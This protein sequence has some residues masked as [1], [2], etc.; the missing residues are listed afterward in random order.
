MTKI[1]FDLSH[2][3]DEML[4]NGLQLAG[5]DKHFFIRGRIKDLKNQLPNEFCPRRIIDFGC[6]IGE[7]TRYLAAAF[8]NSEIL[9]LDTAKEALVYAKNKVGSPRISFKLIQAFSEIESVDLC[10]ING[11]FHHI[12]PLQRPEAIRLISRALKSGGYLC[13]FENNSWSPA[14][15]LVMN[16]I[17]FDQDAQ[18]LSFLEAKHLLRKVGGFQCLRTRFLFYFP[19]PLALLRVAEP[20]LVKLPLG[21]QYFI[22]AVKA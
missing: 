14:A 4:N 20:W 16:R 3:Y 5:E 18:L 12:S 7:T 19:R 2:E 6:G 11:V 17:P 1:L 22:L 15:R 8:P 13:F 10:Y 21:A 9:G